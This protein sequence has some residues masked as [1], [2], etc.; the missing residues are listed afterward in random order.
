MIK[1]LLKLVFLAGSLGFLAFQFNLNEHLSGGNYFDFLS[2]FDF[3]ESFKQFVKEVKDANRYEKA[4]LQLAKENRTL[5]V[6]V[7]ELRYRISKLQAGKKFWELKFKE[8]TASRSLLKPVDKKNDMVR[9]G[10]YQWK[11]KELLKIARKELSR[12]NNVKSAQYFYTLIQN[13]PQSTLINDVVLFQSGVASFQSKI[14][15][16]WA[17]DSFTKLINK[18]PRSQYYRGA[19]LWRALSH[20]EQGEKEKFYVTVE[21]FRLKYRN[22]PE[23]KVLGK[24]YEKSIRSSKI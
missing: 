5:K 10:V 4:A 7:S 24:Y 1:R 3:E 12:K 18:F 8:E 21:E 19:K 13:Y 16:S 2:S 14:Y 22:S 11:D 6:R 17:D 9:F 15:Y 23:W 20:F